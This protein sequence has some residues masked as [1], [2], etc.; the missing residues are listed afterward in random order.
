V[1]RSAQVTSVALLIAAAG[2]NGTTQDIDAS[3]ACVTKLMNL[4]PAH[5]AKPASFYSNDLRIL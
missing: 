2:H 4:S 1:Q 5:S 3:N